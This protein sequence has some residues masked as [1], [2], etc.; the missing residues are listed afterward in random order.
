LLPS[1]WMA[2]GL[3]AAARG[4]PGEALF[5]LALVSSNG[6]FLY[7]LTAWT[8]RRFYSRGYNRMVAGMMFRKR[9]RGHL[10]DRVLSGL[11]VFLSPQTRLLLVKDFRTFRRDPKQWAQVLI[12]AGL[13]SLYLLNLP[14]LYL[15]EISWA[16][17]NGIS[18]LNLVATAFLLCAYTGRFI[19]PMLSLE[20]NKFWILGLLPLQRERV[21]WGKFA[22][23]ALGGL[24]IAEFLT[25]L[26]DFMLR[27]PPLIVGLHAL[28]VAVLALGLSG[29]SV[30]LGA[31]I[32]NFQENDPSKIAVGFGGTLNLVAGV[33]F[34]VL[35]LAAMAG[36]WH[37]SVMDVQA[38][39]DSVP[40]ELGLYVAAGV[41]LWRALGAAA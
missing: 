33:L 11:A 29:L 15:E 30:G 23:S 40:P 34:L 17:Q 14:R 6:L 10:L 31:A 5:Q 19:F 35:T 21:L 8:A 16:Y 1:N 41:G 4:E 36:P 18:F 28:T 13:L 27:V 2:R 12:F 38:P 37:F 22:F 32:P 20:G 3:M 24:F 26:G 25:L 7:L 39:L 9:Y